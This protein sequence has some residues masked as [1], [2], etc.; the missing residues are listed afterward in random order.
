[1]NYLHEHF[2][3]DGNSANPPLVLP[4]WCCRVQWRVRGITVVWEVSPTPPP[5]GDC[6]ST[7]EQ[8]GKVDVTAGTLSEMEVGAVVMWLVV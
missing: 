1:L 5:R 6:C 8:C 2:M 3:H 4:A 7:V